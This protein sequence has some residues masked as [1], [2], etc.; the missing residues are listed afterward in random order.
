M[1]FK[2]RNRVTSGYKLAGR[3]DHYGLDIVG[4]DD[5]KIG[6]TVEGVVVQS[7]MVPK[8]GDR[9]W[10]WGNYVIVQDKKGRR[11]IF[12]HMAS[13]NV[14]KGQ[15]VKKGDIL[16]VMGNT[17][18]SFGAHTHYEVR[19]G[20]SA[21][22]QID[23]SDF[24]GVLNA[25]GTYRQAEPDGKVPM[26][27]EK[28]VYTEKEKNKER[29]DMKYRVYDI[30]FAKENEKAAKEEFLLLS[31]NTVK[32]FILIAP[33]PALGGDKRWRIAKVNMAVES[34]EAA[35]EGMGPDKILA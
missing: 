19:G 27:Q 5:T 1:I 12:A 20:D 21:G 6:C 29:E 25:L 7:R 28:P 18:Y 26:A 34:L 16:G 17:G 9:T 22:S 23:P 8:G 33:Q 14:V 32:E 31:R 15:Q 3:K 11:H 35:M 2:G 10:E 30:V 4:D 24:A 13:R